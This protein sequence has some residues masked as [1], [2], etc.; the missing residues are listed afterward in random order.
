MKF[1]IVLAIFVYSPGETAMSRTLSVLKISKNESTSQLDEYWRLFME[2]N[3]KTYENS[4]I[5]V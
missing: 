3:N 1:L 2:S 4:S 5:E